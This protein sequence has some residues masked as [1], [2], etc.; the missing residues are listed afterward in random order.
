VTNALAH[1]ALRAI[2]VVAIHRHE[3]RQHVAVA[4]VLTAAR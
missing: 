4:E 2:A 1:S 3:R